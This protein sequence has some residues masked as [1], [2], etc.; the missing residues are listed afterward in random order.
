ML[1]SE[2]LE[3]I[4]NGENSGVEFKRDDVRPEQLAKEVVALANLQGGHILLGVEDD[5][6]ISGL[7]R[8][9]EGAQEWVLNTFRDKIHP[10]IIPYY[11]E[12]MFDN[13]KRVGVVTLSAGISKPYTLRHNKREEVY[14]RM[15]NRSELASREQQ[16]RLFE[17]GG[18]LHV[19]AWP[20]AGSSIDSLDLIR[21]SHYLEAI[22]GE[23][24]IP[25]EQEE[26]IERLSGLG[27]MVDDGLGNRVCSIAGLVSF[28][29]Q[30]RRY[31]KYSGLRLLVFEGIEKEYQAKLDEHLEGPLVARW[32]YQETGK[33]D[34]IDQGLIEKLV[35]AIMP[36][37]TAESE[38][39]DEHFRRDRVWHY[40]YEAIREVCLNALAHR[41]W[42]RSIEVEVGVY[43]DRL[44]VMSPGALQNSMTVEK[45]KAGQRSPRNY[46]IMDILR[47]HG[48]VDSRGMGIRKKVIPLMKKQNGTNPVFEVTEDYVKV[49]LFKK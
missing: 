17:Q 7:V 31:L 9:Q 14:L 2:L 27:L 40:P 5:G 11:E 42:T 16:A 13:D 19:E 20:V 47:D 15:G 4:A 37:V 36:F 21:V 10:Q 24:E 28:G 46:N 25:E 22:L 44:E 26:W 18:M 12:V 39:L 41:D 49:I 32:H 6:S 1:K 43:S 34:L 35:A 29:I 8:D 30:P 38:T 48:Y 3:I 45:M 23:E 33:R